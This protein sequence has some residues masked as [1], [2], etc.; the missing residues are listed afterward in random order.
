MFKRRRKKKQKPEKSMIGK[1]V[2]MSLE[3]F[4]EE[5]VKQKVNVGTMNN[6]ILNLEGIYYELR[7]RKMV[8]S[9]LS[10]M[11]RRQKMTQ[12]FSQL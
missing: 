9:N 10:L 6:L 5:L 12:R 4:K 1:I 11:A 8:L 3:D 7:M 2:D